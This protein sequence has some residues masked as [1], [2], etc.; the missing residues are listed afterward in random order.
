MLLPNH[1]IKLFNVLLM[2]TKSDE[3]RDPEIK[4]LYSCSDDGEIFTGIL[5]DTYFKTAYEKEGFNA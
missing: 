1:R 3:Q 5:K 2:E 4:Q